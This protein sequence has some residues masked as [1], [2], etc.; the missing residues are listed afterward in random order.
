MLASTKGTNVVQVYM[1]YQQHET[2]C[3]ITSAT[4]EAIAKMPPITVLMPPQ[5]DKEG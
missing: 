3:A 4:L 2:T 5:G 1:K